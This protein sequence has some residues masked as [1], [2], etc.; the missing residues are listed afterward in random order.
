VATWHNV[1][2]RHSVI[3]F[4]TPVQ[5]HEDIDTALLENRVTV[6]E[7]AKAHNPER[8]SGETRNWKPVLVANLNPEKP[9]RTEI[10]QPL[11]AHPL[12]K[13]AT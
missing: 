4:M 8:W 9:L 3:K 7:A 10:N 12:I 5:R 2:H 6:Y 13:K 11:E 1:E